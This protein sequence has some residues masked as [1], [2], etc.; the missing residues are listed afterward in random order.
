[1]IPGKA[2]RRAHAHLERSGA[3]ADGL[4][5]DLIATATENMSEKLLD[6]GNVRS[7]GL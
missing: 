7:A 3:Y 6:E 5:S 2:V 4:L 1:L